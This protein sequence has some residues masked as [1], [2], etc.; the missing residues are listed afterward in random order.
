MAEDYNEAEREIL[1]Q[2][3]D[4]SDLYG[5]KAWKAYASL[6]ESQIATREALIMDSAPGTHTE[7]ELERIKGA[8]LGLRLAL[9]NLK[10]IMDVAKEIRA[11]HQGSDDSEEESES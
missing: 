7:L 2:A 3:R 5:S 8:R 9:D 4:M 11:S 1:R 6:L 10:T